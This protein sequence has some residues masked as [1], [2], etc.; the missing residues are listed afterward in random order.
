M[1]TMTEEWIDDVI[2]FLQYEIEA[3]KEETDTIQIH[4]KACEH[5]LCPKTEKEWENFVLLELR[6]KNLYQ[7]CFVYKKLF[8]ELL[9]N[10][11]DHCFANNE[12]GVATFTSICIGYIDNPKKVR[13]AFEYVRQYHWRD[14]YFGLKFTLLNNL[15]DSR[16][17][18]SKKASKK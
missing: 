9:E 18:A 12:G 17:K 10:D 5:F 6:H 7:Y 3:F 15:Y 13:E 1:A 4:R 8:D 11:G 14:Y 2:E 16:A